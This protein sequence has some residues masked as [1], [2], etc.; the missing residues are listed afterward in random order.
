[1]AVFVQGPAWQFKSWPWGGL[2]VEIFSRMKG[3]H[4][5]WDE[6][7]LDDNVAKWNVQVLEL[8]RTKRHLDKA[9]LMRFWASLEGFMI[10]YKQF[11]KF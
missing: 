2:P 5:K 6:A 10:K 1:M 8:S 11:L 7:K 4:L 9:N 3:F